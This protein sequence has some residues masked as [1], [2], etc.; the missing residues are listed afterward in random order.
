FPPEEN[1]ALAGLPRSNA[2]NNRISRLERRD[3]TAKKEI[4]TAFSAAAL[5]F[6]VRRRLD[7]RTPC[8]LDHPLGIRRLSLPFI[9]HGIL[10]PFSSVRIKFDKP[11]RADNIVKF[12]SKQSS[13][14]YFL[15]LKDEIDGDKKTVIPIFSPM[16]GAFADKWE[17][18]HYPPHLKK[19]EV[20]WSSKPQFG[21]TFLHIP[22]YWEWTE[23]IIGRCTTTLMKT[24]L[25][26]AVYASM[27]LYKCNSPLMQRFCEFWCPTTNTVLTGD[28]EAFISLWDLRILR[29][30]PIYGAFYDEVIPT[31]LEYST[32]ILPKAV[33]NFSHF[34]IPESWSNKHEA[35]TLLNVPEEHRQQTYLAAFLSCWLCA[36]VLPLKNLGCISPS[37]FKPASQLA[38]GQR[39]S[40]AIPVLA[41]IYRGLNEISRSLTPGRS[42]SNFSAHYVHAWTAQYFRSHCM[43]VHDFAGAQMIAFHGASNVKKLTSAE[44]KVFIRSG[45]DINWIGNCMR[46]PK[47]R[48]LIDDSTLRQDVDFLLSI[49]SCFL[50]LRYDNDLVVESYSPHRFSRQFGFCQNIP[51]ALKPDSEEPSLQYLWSLFQTS[52]QVGTKSS[53]I[54]P[55]SGM[56]N[57]IRSRTTTLFKLWWKTSYSSPEP[58]PSPPLVVSSQ[59]RKVD[60]DSDTKADSSDKGESKLQKSSSQSSREPSPQRGKE[61]QENASS[62]FPDERTIFHDILG[63]QA[64]D[65][66]D[67]VKELEIMGN[68][69]AFNNPNAKELEHTTAS[70]DPSV[71]VAA[72]DHVAMYAAATI[73]ARGTK[74]VNESPAIS[75]EA[76][77]FTARVMIS[78]ADRCEARFLAQQMRAKLLQTPLSNIPALDPELKEL[79][80]LITSKN[81]DVTSL[82][83]HVGAYVSH[84]SFISGFG[85]VRECP[86]FSI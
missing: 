15:V 67:Y 35:L 38:S 17:T 13:A 26:D 53:F 28:G 68:A 51:G 18:D 2:N 37:V 80:G 83:E 43:S 79:F 42:C 20:T 44:A 4:P 65:V 23:D 36:F 71:L 70:I 8:S 77:S 39:I 31:A 12:E 19:W 61:G 3:R 78:A 45:Q 69:F 22:L 75:M 27:F 41:S 9:D 33:E 50:T 47:D 72:S 55:A 74:V 76:P 52:T 11:S 21:V 66:F 85:L 10:L 56:N 86:S 24:D 49:R 34:G 48:L 59:K 5:S 63:D 7:Y 82:R 73:I 40:L 64:E 16:T 30:L 32:T 25:I 54:I 60:N 57:E 81:I 1:S 84:A 6:S 46:N 14:G 29:G 58:S 62:Q